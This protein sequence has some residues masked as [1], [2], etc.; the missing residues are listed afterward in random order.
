MKDLNACTMMTDTDVPFS[1]A[2][3]RAASHSSS[4]TRTDLI[5]VPRDISRLP[6]AERG[7]QLV[8]ETKRRLVR[9]LG[10]DMAT[11][12]V[13]RT[14]FRGA[15]DNLKAHWELQ[16]LLGRKI[17]AVFAGA[18]ECDCGLFDCDTG[19]VGADSGFG[20]VHFSTF[21]SGCNYTLAGCMH[22]MQVGAKNEGRKAIGVEIE[23]RYCEIAARRLSQDVLDIEG[24]AV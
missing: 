4:G 14:L 12:G 22:T 3:S 6:R 18:F 20:E 21:P 1:S 23:E 16:T 7:L 2:F 17:F 13:R 11:L 15:F 8:I 19:V 10:L 24:L 9:A 5:G